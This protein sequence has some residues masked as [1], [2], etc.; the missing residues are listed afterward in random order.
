MD[1]KI[2]DRRKKIRKKLV[3]VKLIKCLGYFV[4]LLFRLYTITTVFP[5]FYLILILFNVDVVLCQIILDIFDI[6]LQFIPLSFLIV[7]EVKSRIIQEELE[8]Y[9]NGNDKEVD[10]RIDKKLIIHDDTCK[11]IISRFENLSREK[12]MELL[13]YI[14]G[15]VLLNK[16][17]LCIQI[18]ELNIMEKEELQTELEDILFPDFDEFDDVYRKNRRK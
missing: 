13:N 7:G 5:F 18:D 10:K 9:G 3:I 17:Q 15:D 8:F 11:D 6:V 12:Q 14:K 1:N 2:E 16:N 4:G